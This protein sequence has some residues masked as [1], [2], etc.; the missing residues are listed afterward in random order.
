MVNAGRIEQLAGAEDIYDRPV[1][2]FV[3]NFVGESNVVSGVLKRAAGGAGWQIEVPQHAAIGALNPGA[4]T[5]GARAMVIIRPERIAVSAGQ[6]D[7]DVKLNGVIVERLYAG[8]NLRLEVRSGDLRFV[9][10]VSASVAGARQ[11]VAGREVQ[12]G[13]NVSDAV[14]LPEVAGGAVH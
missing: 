14:Y 9:V 8:S 5:E 12:I 2:A 11:A 7:A 6:L 3:A 10:V 1:T 4:M 13:W